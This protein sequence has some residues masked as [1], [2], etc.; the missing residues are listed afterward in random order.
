[1]SQ[2]KL[3]PQLHEVMQETHPALVPLAFRT[4]A[5]CPA[6]EAA[7]PGTLVSEPAF[8]RTQTKTLDGWP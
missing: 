6:Q 4:R 8:G 2:V 1:M 3:S 5:F 7:C